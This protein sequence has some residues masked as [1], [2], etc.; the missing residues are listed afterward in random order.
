MQ[1]NVLLGKPDPVKRRFIL[2]KF[3][4][5]QAGMASNKN[6]KSIDFMTNNEKSLALVNKNE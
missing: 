5:K 3:N 2:N 1:K 6:R 4:L